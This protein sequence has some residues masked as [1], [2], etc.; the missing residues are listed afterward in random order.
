MQRLLAKIWVWTILQ[1]K[2]SCKEVFVEIIGGRKFIELPGDKKFELPPLIL[3]SSTQCIP[4]L[5]DAAKSIVEEDILPEIE[6]NNQ[7]DQEA[8]TVDLG[9]NLLKQ[10]TS[11]LTDW[12]TGSEI[13][14]WI[15]DC[16]L[17]FKFNPTLHNLLRPDVWPHSGRRSFIPLLLDKKIFPES[18]YVQKA[19]G[20]SL[21]F[22]RPPPISCLTDQ[23]LMYL[24]KGV[25]ET[26][27]LR[28]ADLQPPPILD[29]PA[30]R[31]D[32][33]VVKM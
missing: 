22:R 32:F 25:A 10:Y 23:F 24:N 12:T 28:W 1:D 19:V 21:M 14:G 7:Q 27:Y 9:I 11:L 2:Q 17:G 20:L 4:G 31:F 13:I 8:R 30:E 29:L 5:L 18:N 6:I 16:E 26:V 15:K 33:M 3:G